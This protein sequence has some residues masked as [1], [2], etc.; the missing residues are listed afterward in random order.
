MSIATTASD[1]GQSEFQII[2]C[3]IASGR[4]EPFALDSG[5]ARHERCTSTVAAG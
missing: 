1:S 5:A 2:R 4:R 3:T